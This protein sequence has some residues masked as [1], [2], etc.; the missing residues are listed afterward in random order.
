MQIEPNDVNQPR[1]K[2]LTRGDQR[3]KGI[4]LAGGSGTRLHPLTRA[5]SKQLLPVFD[6]PL[7][8]FPL[9]ILM[10]AGIRE[11]LVITTGEDQRSFQALLGDGR[12][13]GIELNYAIQA[14]PNGLAEALLIGRGFLNGQP[15]CL[16]L[17]DN[18]FIGS[19]LDQELCIAHD[20]AQ[21]ASVFGYE[22]PDPERYGVVEFD[23][24]GRAVS[25][26]EKPPRP[27]SN[28]AVTGLYFYDNQ[29]SEIAADL[30]PSARGEL[31]ITDLNAAYL[32][33]GL[34]HVHKLGR[35]CAWFDAGTHESLFAAASYVR[36]AQKRQG[37]QIACPE[38]I[39]FAQG[40]IGTAELE[41]LADQLGKTHYGG[42]LKGL[43]AASAK[44]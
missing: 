9:T 8:Y 31:E 16:V 6:K 14:K 19:Q 4:I 40:Y 34:L 22:V 2:P 27:R 37:I 20:R 18:I 41:K 7:I 17:G 3:R 28:Y 26:E 1:P 30:R 5:V 25:L 10:L 42:Y 39:A 33:R 43:L 24:D 35:E 13:W 21:G 36:D 23:L 44:G 12:Q 32:A 38:E 15:S 11:I 29:A